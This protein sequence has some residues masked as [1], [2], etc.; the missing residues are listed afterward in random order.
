MTS[1]FS[2]TGV[3]TSGASTFGGTFVPV[4]HPT[5]VTNASSKRTM[6][7][8]LLRI[9]PPLVF[10]LLHTHMTAGKSDLIGLKP[11]STS[12]IVLSSEC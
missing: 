4:E 5:L 3:I 7:M 6:M 2:W 11:D 8:L 12:A 9:A 1:G 10:M